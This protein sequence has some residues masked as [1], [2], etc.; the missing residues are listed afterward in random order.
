[1]GGG[2]GFT[3][4]GC[5]SGI[6]NPFWEGLVVAEG[7]IKDKHHEKEGEDDKPDYFERFGIRFHF[8]FFND[9]LHDVFS[10]YNIVSIMQ[11]VWEILTYMV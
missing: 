6:D 2:G 7:K 4:V 9:F 10:L 1:M 5:P 8:W 3:E 11:S